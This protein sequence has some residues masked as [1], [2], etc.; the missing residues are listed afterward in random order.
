MNQ[1][2]HLP[3]IETFATYCQRGSKTTTSGANE[4]EPTTELSALE[5]SG[6]AEKATQIASPILGLPSADFSDL[7]VS[8]LAAASFMGGHA[9]ILAGAGTGKTRTIIARCEYLIANGVPAGRI[10]VLTFTRKAAA[11]I[12]ARVSAKFGQAA[13]ELKA[14]T[15]HAFCMGLIHRFPQAFGCKGC[16]VIDS[17]D[18]VELM[19]MA[20]AASN[21]EAMPTASE[22][23]WAPVN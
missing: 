16:S 15:F 19:R 4:I 3:G 6:S 21:S 13:K 20:R 9:L 10:Y 8:Q 23:D 1:Q 12:V 7:N 5:P 14:S 2:P 18:Q 17:D 11:E 22:L